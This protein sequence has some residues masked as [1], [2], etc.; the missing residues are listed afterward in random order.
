MV[1]ERGERM[2]KYLS[3]NSALT[4]IGSRLK[5]YRIDYQLTQ[6]ELSD[7]S[8]VA[9]RSIS[10]ME[11]GEDIQFGN[12]I[13]V[14]IALDLDENLDMLVPNPSIRPSYYLK[15]KMVTSKRERVGKKKNETLIKE[16]KWGERSNE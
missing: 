1:S 14:L 6:K 12:L 8:G 10:R 5:A 4:E 2:S 13:K 7:K 3:S 16:I 9:V 11:S 15:N